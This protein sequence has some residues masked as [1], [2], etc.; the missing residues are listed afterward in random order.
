METQIDVR[1]GDESAYTGILQFQVAKGFD[2]YSQDVARQL[3]HPLYELSAEIDEPF[4][5]GEAA[6]SSLLI[7]ADA[8]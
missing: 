2:P 1:S 7:S 4:A 8:R 6:Y 3:S 5:H